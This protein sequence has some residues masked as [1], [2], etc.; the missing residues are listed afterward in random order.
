MR[1]LPRPFGTVAKAGASTGWSAVPLV[2]NALGATLR[3]RCGGRMRP[4]PTH[5]LARPDPPQ[6]RSAGLYFGL[7]FSLYLLG[8]ARRG[9]GTQKRAVC[10]LVPYVPL[11]CDTYGVLRSVRCGGGRALRVAASLERKD[12]G[13]RP[14]GVGGRAGRGLG[15]VLFL[16]FDPAFV[17]APECH[18]LAS[19]GLLAAGR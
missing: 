16:V 9:A 8:T 13:P 14:D 15:L 6:Y 10:G 17:V 1:A 18:G 7:S 4:P 19:I 11:R 12:A 3:G 2:C 5:L